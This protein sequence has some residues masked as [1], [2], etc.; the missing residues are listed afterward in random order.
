M[1]TGFSIREAAIIK[2]NPKTFPDAV[3]DES[4]KV[5]ISNARSH[6]CQSSGVLI[7]EREGGMGRRVDSQDASALSFC[8]SGCRDSEADHCWAPRGE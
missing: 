8:V 5:P 7:T 4:R 3:N 6:A 2:T 1:S